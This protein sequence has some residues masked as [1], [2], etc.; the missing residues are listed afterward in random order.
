MTPLKQQISLVPFSIEHWYSPYKWRRFENRSDQ[1][2]C[3]LLIKDFFVC[4]RECKPLPTPK[5]ETKFIR[6]RIRIFGL[7]QPVTLTHQTMAYRLILNTKFT[8]NSIFRELSSIFVQ[9][10]IFAQ[11]QSKRPLKQFTVEAI[12]KFSSNK[13]QNFTM[14]SPRTFACIDVLQAFFLQFQL[15]TTRWYTLGR[16]C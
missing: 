3:I 15:V 6:I 4:N 13:F 11:Y 5:F 1:T 9:Y 7:I 8:K 10:W 2:F 16:L 14:R 12:T